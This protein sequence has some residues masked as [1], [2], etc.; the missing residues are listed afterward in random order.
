MTAVNA[1]PEE[2]VITT[3]TM[4][5]LDKVMQ[6]EKASFT[7][8]WSRQAFVRE[9]TENT[10]AV[11]VVGRLGTKV[12]GYAGMWLIINEAHVTN[13]A[14]HPDYRRRHFG[15]RLLQELIDRAKRDNCDRMTLEVRTGNLGARAMYRRFGFVEQGIRRR[16]YTDTGE[17]AIIMWKDEL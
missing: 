9:L 14:V 1:A 11:Y 6:V 12:V 13:I 16:Y 15:E 7:T 2:L 3:M 10:F 8:P 5:D 17:D 4:D